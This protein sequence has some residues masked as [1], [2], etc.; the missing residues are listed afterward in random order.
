MRKIVFLSLLVVFLFFLLKLVS[1][2]QKNVDLYFFYGQGCP[3]CTRAE[4]FLKELKT[5]Y[6]N[7]SVVSFEV[8]NNQENRK[9][10]FALAQAYKIETG[11]V[12]GFFINDKA[13]IGYDDFNAFQIRNEI[14]KCLNQKCLSP[15]EKLLLGQ[16]SFKKSNFKIQRAIGWVI[17]IL[18]VGLLIFVAVKLLKKNK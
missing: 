2:Q 15:A 5:K 18:L 16:D 14:L 12:P 7:L 11:A 9:L 3:F 8:Y 17:I 6:P 4:F 13:F 10:Y 1:A